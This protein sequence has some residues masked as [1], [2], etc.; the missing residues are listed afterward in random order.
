M[1]ETG[2]LLSLENVKVHFPVRK[3][4]FKTAMVRAVDGVSLTVRKGETLALVGESG[5]G[6]TTL[7]RVSLRLLKPTAGQVRYKGND[8]TQATEQ[9]LTEFRKRCGIIFQDPYSSLDPFM[10]VHQILEEPLTVHKVGNPSERRKMINRVLENVRLLPVEEFLGKYPH[11]LSGGQRQR[12]AVARTL[13]LEPE[14]VVADEPVSMIDA[15]SRAEILQLLAQLQKK[16]S[17]SFFYITH[18]IATAKYF[19][20]K[21]AIMYLGR[22]VEI[23]PTDEVLKDPLHPYSEALKAAVPDPDPNNRFVMRRTLAGEPPSPISPPS[24]CPFHQ[25]CPYAMPVCFRLE[26]KLVEIRQGHFVA[27]FLHSTESDKLMV[28]A[29]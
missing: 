24:G 1:Q 7:G 28:S 4:L 5:C 9:E 3:R 25:R 15:S 23:G 14:Y 17:I 10:S 19:S 27:C 16:H 13:I 26:P 29:S 8:I 2:N 12:V 11:M 18:D 22:I 6:K 20:D 21:L